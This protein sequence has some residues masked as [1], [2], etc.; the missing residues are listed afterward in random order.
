MNGFEGI[1]ENEMS[2]EDTE[3]S[4]NDQP[5][6]IMNNIGVTQHLPK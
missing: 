3:R 1:E 4:V 6:K 5:I 2:V